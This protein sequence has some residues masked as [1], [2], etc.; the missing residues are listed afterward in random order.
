M[1]LH[2]VVKGYSLKTC[3][4]WIAVDIS[5]KEKSYRIQTLPVFSRI[6]CSV[7]VYLV[8]KKCTV[9]PV[10][11]IRMSGIARMDWVCFVPEVVKGQEPT[12][13]L[14]YCKSHL[15]SGVFNFRILHVRNIFAFSRKNALHEFKQQ[16]NERKKT[17]AGRGNRKHSEPCT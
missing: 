15:I 9:F 3:C 2:A 17:D 5:V 11:D 1:F 10:Q 16:Q 8:F 4:G 6:F 14:L 12:D 7:S 13:L